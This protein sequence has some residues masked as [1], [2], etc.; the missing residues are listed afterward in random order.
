MFTRSIFLRFFI[1]SILFLWRV[2]DVAN[3]Q[4]ANITGELKAFHKVTFSWDGPEVDESATTFKNYRMDVTFISPDSQR[5][6]VPGYFAADGWAAES[7]ATQGKKW[8]C[9]F[10]PS[11]SGVWSYKVSFRAG[12]NIA[13]ESSVESGA[14]TPLL[15]LPR[16]G[17]HFS[18]FLR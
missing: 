13:I 6:V 10:T 16:R 1:I 18:A 8:R 17:I 15:I 2:S 5:F 3:A 9:H 11:E 14:R 7:G 12:D 4:L